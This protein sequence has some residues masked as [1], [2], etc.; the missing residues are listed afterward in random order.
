MVT[1]AAGFSVGITLQALVLTAMFARLFAVPMR[2]VLRQLLHSSIA[3]LLG[4]AAAYG[5]L[6]FIVEGVNQDTFLGVFIQGAVGFAFGTAGI[7]VAYFALKSPELM[8]IAKSFRAKIFK[9][10]VVAPQPDVL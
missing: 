6:Q 10:D 3:A 8:E 2:G 7:I 5:A 4:G 9:T 1:L